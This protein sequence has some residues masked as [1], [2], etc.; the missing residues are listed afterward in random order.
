MAFDPAVISQIPDYAPN[1]AAAKAQAFRLQ[2]LV[3]TEQLNALRLNE[4]K[5]QVADQ[6]K[7]KELLKSE[8]LSTP[9]GISKAASRLTQAG[10]PEQ[11]L[12][13]MGVAQQYQTGAMEQQL[14]QMEVATKQ[15]DIIAGGL[16]EVYGQLEALQK[17]GASPDTLDRAAQVLGVDAIKRLQQAHPELGQ[18]LTAFAQDPKN[19]TFAGIKQAEVNSNHYQ[20]MMKTK[21]AELREQNQER[22][23][24]IA[25]RREGLAERKQDQAEQERKEGIISDDAAQTAVDRI[26]NGEQARDVLA[27]FG[28]G[29]QGA[30]NITKVQ[31]LLADTARSRGIS[32][33]DISARMVEFKGLVKEQQVEA[34]IA[35]RIS[36]A[37]KE[38]QQIGPKVIEIANKL[39]RGQFVPWNKLRNI[40]AKNIS[41]PTLKQLQ[42]Y[43]TTLTNSYDVLGGRGGTDVEKRAHNRELLDAA[44][45]PEALK[46]AV[47]AITQEAALSRTAA[48]ESMAVGRED[49]PGGQS[50]QPAQ[51]KTVNWNDLR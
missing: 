51:S 15:T 47:D 20:Q 50:T 42:A 25:E 48:K 19:L 24:N 27:N 36:Y 17:S 32:P 21:L 38:I 9:Q 33:Q 6:Q 26:L 10:L 11:G 7:M 45:S 30:A 29:K 37:E 3:N 22:L 39:G 1:P 31:N 4:E 12:K 49:L 35:G 23:G 41:D 2:D 8:D 16:D 13:L 18:Y 43:L 28:R 14:R 44:D 40:A 46:A 34:G 5:T